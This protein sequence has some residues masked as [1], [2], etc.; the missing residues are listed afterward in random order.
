MYVTGK[1]TV[2]NT[3]LVIHQPA[4]WEVVFNCGE[5]E[6]C[7]TTTIDNAL[8]LLIQLFQCLQMAED[9]VGLLA[10]TTAN[11][12]AMD[13]D[14]SNLNDDYETLTRNATSSFK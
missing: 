3:Q 2:T 10:A 1:E 6:L 7:Q 8:Q 9:D 5:S 14:L 13:I 12:D 11:K 4:S